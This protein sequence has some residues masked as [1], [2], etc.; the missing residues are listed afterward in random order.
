MRYSRLRIFELTILLILLLPTNAAFL[1]TDQW[2]WISPLPQGQN[3]F[4][5]ATDGQKLLAVGDSGVILSSTDATNWTVRTLPGSPNLRSLAFG[6][7][8]WVA[9]GSG[10]HLSSSSDAIFWAQHPLG[11]T[12]D[13]IGVTYGDG[14]F[15]AWT[16][17][18]ISFHS[19]NGQDWTF[20]QILSHTRQLLIAEGV[21][22]ALLS[23]YAHYVSSD[24]LN[25][26]PAELA[27]THAVTYTNG[28][29][30]GI[31]SGAAHISDDGRM[32]SRHST[33]VDALTL[34]PSPSGLYAGQSPRLYHSADGRGYTTVTSSM[35][36][37][38]DFLPFKQLLLG[39]GWSGSIF[40]S[41]NGVDW[42]PQHRFL[43]PPEDGLPNLFLDASETLFVHNSKTIL[44]TT[45]AQ[46]WTTV[47]QISDDW[48][49]EDVAV[50]ANH[51][52]AIARERILGGAA[53]IFRSSNGRNWT[54]VLGI[55]NPVQIEFGQNRFVIVTT[56][57]QF[58]WSEDGLQWNLV[59]DAL[60]TY[61]ILHLAYNAGEF[62]AL[63]YRMGQTGDWVLQE[64]AT[65]GDGRVWRVRPSP[66]RV[67][68]WNAVAK[69]LPIAGG[70]L[71]GRPP[72]FSGGQRSG[73]FWTSKDLLFDLLLPL[74]E[75]ILQIRVWKNTLL[76]VNHIGQIR[77]S[78][79]F[80]NVTITSQNST[81]QVHF[82]G[83]VP[84]KPYEIST[85]PSI[86][87]TQKL[88]FTP[89]ATTHTLTINP[90]S[91]LG[92]LHLNSAKLLAR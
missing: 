21:F 78:A 69:A 47:G 63:A 35:P 71:T 56:L 80:V 92:F 17:E 18:G 44:S 2:H 70:Y 82:E 13:F 15:V 24:G 58:W 68:Y 77:R 60:T 49:L 89:T 76:T 25:W 10:G 31:S 30:Y 81:V 14:Q 67:P 85:T 54:P 84:N 37:L 23:N 16:R 12:S 39:V 46:S 11:V 9:V 51:F 52:V 19:S 28:K 66:D 22:I 65:S 38:M 87:P 4:A 5:L 57:G 3:V 27:P 42:T 34:V 20:R 7:N 83:L 50:G 32:W 74:N 53:A 41:Q 1:M 91:H 8:R 55:P 72:T 36:Q 86:N 62:I 88:T 45:D 33:T 75:P 73:L 29:F 61:P 59:P 48:A 26:T 43:L 79:A 40:T 6:N 90:E 64:Y